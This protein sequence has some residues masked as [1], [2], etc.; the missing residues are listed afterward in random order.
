MQKYYITTKRLWVLLAQFHKHFYI[1]LVSTIIGQ[2]IQ[3]FAIYLLS[4]VLNDIINKQYDNAIAIAVLGLLLQAIRLVIQYFTEMHAAK[5]LDLGIQQYLE[6]Y[7]F[8]NIFNLNASQYA[9]D[10]SAIKLQVIDRGENAVENIVSTI[11]LSLLPTISMVTF[12]VFAIAL[13]SKSVAVVV[14]FTLIVV[15]YWTNRF[16]NYQRPFIKKN[17]DNWDSQRK[18]RAE[19]YTHL[20][21]IKV[22]G[23][24]LNYLKKYLKN[25]AEFLDYK[26]NVIKMSTLHGH[27]RWGFFTLTR[28]VNI[29]VVI[30]LAKAGLVA[31][32]TI[33]AIWRWTDDAYGQIFNVIV[34]MRQIPLKFVELEK[35]LAIID[36]QPDFD[37]NGKEKFVAGDIVFEHMSFK[38]PHGDTE[39]IK[40]F[41]LTIPVGKKVA[42]VGH[43]GSG[44]TTITRLLLRMYDWGNGDIKIAGV[45]LRDINSKDLRK[46][47]G[48]VEQHVELFDASVREN[49]MFG[50]HD[51]QKASD[52]QLEEIAHKARI[53]Q[54][55]HRLGNDKFETVIGERGIK[56]SGGERQRI[57]IARALIKNPSLLIFDE[58]TSALDTENEKY[59]KEAIDEA[60]VGR[61]TVII[62]HRL[63]T[64]MDADMIVVMERGQI[65]GVGNHT[66][67]E[68][69]CLPY[70]NLIAAQI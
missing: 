17:M 23:V 70:Q 13:Y 3:V 55:Y 6:E 60:S 68:T 4:L 35:Y 19:A 8:K 59:I 1:Q 18:I 7:T 67:L 61:T 47:V 38:Y 65:V 69:S 36:K 40:D 33:Y 5:Y 53:D 64:I 37:E 24:E 15:M 52:K 39:I 28:V 12:S 20:S 57:G 9:E 31:V 51:N 29:I 54:F 34:A 44:K 42:F 45:S 46:H 30:N 32:G 14:L 49:I 58:A 48:Y 11:I 66:E 2:G 41:N 21:L 50:L 25:R 63:S 26:L 10:H 43:S 22:L 56:L 16:S 62:A 27:T